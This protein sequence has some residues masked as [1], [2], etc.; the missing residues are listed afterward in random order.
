MENTTKQ[1]KFLNS[2]GINL[3]VCEGL[4]IHNPQAIIIQIHGIGGH[5]QFIMDSHDMFEYKNFVFSKKGIKSYGLE[6]TGHGKSDGLKCSIDNYD[7]LVED[8]RSFVLFIKNKHPNLKIFIY[9]ESMGAGL[10]IIYQI[11]YKENSHI[12]GYSFVA[13]MCGITKKVTPNFF[14]LNILLF[15]SNLFPTLKF[16]NVSN[17]MHKASLNN[18]FLKLKLNCRYQYTDSIRLNTARELYRACL[19]LNNNAHLFDSPFYIFH[20]VNDP[21]TPSE[22]SIQF[23]K[24][25]KVKNKKIYLTKNSN[26]VIT[27]PVNNEDKR[28]NIMLHKMLSFFDSLI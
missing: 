24:S 19:F 8:I 14:R 11:K 23:Y 21:I 4:N 6:L 7:D 3:N 9:G 20:S 25:T 26:H 2:K 13:P 28:P 10:S 15:I 27:L 22:K 17:K 18:E 16:I 12:S 1:F 5:F